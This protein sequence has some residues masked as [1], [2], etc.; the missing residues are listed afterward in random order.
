MIRAESPTRFR[1]QPVTVNQNP[2]HAEVMTQ[3]REKLVSG[4]KDGAAVK[5]GAFG[6]QRKGRE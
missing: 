2:I 6:P 4:E 3:Q 1:L 5:K